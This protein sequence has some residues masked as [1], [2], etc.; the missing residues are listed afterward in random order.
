[1]RSMLRACTN[2]AVS[3]AL[4]SSMRTCAPVLQRARQVDMGNARRRLRAVRQ[5][6]RAGER[7]GAFV[8]AAECDQHEPFLHHDGRSATLG[9]ARLDLL[10][11]TGLGVLP[12]IFGRASEESIG[13]SSSSGTSNSRADATDE[14]WDGPASRLARPA[15]MSPA[16]SARGCAKHVCSRTQRAQRVR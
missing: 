2:P 15:A 1:M 6:A 14:A 7:R 10:A 8:E 16:P 13:A 3:S 4:A 12:G 9:D 11:M 5:L